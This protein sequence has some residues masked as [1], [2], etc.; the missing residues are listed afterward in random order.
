MAG[1]IAGGKVLASVNETHN[2]YFRFTGAA[3]VAADGFTINEGGEYISA[4]ARLA[5]G[6]ITVTFRDTWNAVLGVNG[7]S[8]TA[9]SQLVLTSDSIN[10]TTPTLVLRHEVAGSDTDADGAILRGV[11]HLRNSAQ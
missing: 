6:T 4:V 2:L 9:D 3:D 7:S 1:R 10:D 5:E 11:I 8:N